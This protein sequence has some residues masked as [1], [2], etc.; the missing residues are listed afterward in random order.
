[1][2]CKSNI[3]VDNT[4]FIEEVDFNNKIHDNKDI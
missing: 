4:K 1:M 3:N 2:S